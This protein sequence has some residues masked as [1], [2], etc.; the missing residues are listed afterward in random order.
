[1]SL[2][3]FAVTY[4]SSQSTLLVLAL[5]YSSLAV[6][7]I[8]FRYERY[9]P[10]RRLRLL[11]ASFGVAITTWG[12]LASSILLCAAFIG[13]YQ[14]GE[15]LAAVRIVFGLALL[16]SLVVALPVSALVTFKVPRIIAKRLVEELAEPDAAVVDMAKEVARGVGV[17]MLRMLQSSSG[18]PF[19]Y[20]VGGAEGLIVVSKGL[21][22][23]LDDDEVETVLAHELAHLKNHD[24]GLKTLIAV[25][26]RVLFFDP[27]MRLLEAA[28]HSEKE[29]SADEASA[30][31]TKK[32]LSLASALL[33]ISSAQSGG[34][35]PPVKIGGLAILGRSKYLRPPGVKERIERLIALATELQ[36]EELSVRGGLEPDLLSR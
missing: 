1:M 29:F 15:E 31:N 4:F 10:Q 12:F 20:S 24:G 17:S 25:Y 27:F 16:A 22:T 26:R 33:K 34:R 32:P 21:I 30:R 6:V 8:A 14:A 2:L 13:V 3:D 28:I 18:V 23:Q 11:F 19:A 35:G 36:H 5:L 9:R 7:I